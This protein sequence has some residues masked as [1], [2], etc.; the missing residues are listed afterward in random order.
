MHPDAVLPRF[1]HGPH[2]DAGMDL[3][4]VEEVVA[5]VPDFAEQAALAGLR[6][7]FDPS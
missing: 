2:E 5:Q 6:R 7:N 1:A 4:A 3:H